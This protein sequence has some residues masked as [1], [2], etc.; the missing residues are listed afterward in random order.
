MNDCCL[1]VYV[2][3]DG[4][5]ACM[6]DVC[7][8]CWCAWCDFFYSCYVYAWERRHKSSCACVLIAVMMKK[9]MMTQ[10]TR[11][12]EGGLSHELQHSV[13]DTRDSTPSPSGRSVSTSLLFCK[14]KGDF[15]IF[16][17]T[18]CCSLGQLLCRIT[19]QQQAG[20]I[21]GTHLLRQL[22]PK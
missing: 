18:T 4:K 22:V 13:Q 12:G 11:A 14:I 8:V 15:K 10:E 9:M 3:D 20:C 6:C 1:S 17:Q 16:T 2:W 19:S 7:S 5:W 21:S